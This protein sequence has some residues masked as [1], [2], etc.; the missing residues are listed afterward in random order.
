MDATTR[1][2]LVI[3]CSLAGLCANLTILIIVFKVGTPHRAVNSVRAGRKEAYTIILGLAAHAGDC[4]NSALIRQKLLRSRPD[5]PEIGVQV[6]EDLANGWAALEELGH[7]LQGEQL[8]CSESIV[9]LFSDARNKHFWNAESLFRLHGHAALD[10]DA[11]NKQTKDLVAKLKQRCR[12][13]I[14]LTVR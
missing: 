6:D 4:F 13:E 11:L 8:I 7:R 12:R 5:N 14:G 9:A 2:W 1:D 10:L 3:V